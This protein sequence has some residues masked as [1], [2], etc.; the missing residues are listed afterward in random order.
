MVHLYWIGL[1]KNV[2]V[3]DLKF[4]KLVKLLFAL[5][6]AVPFPALITNFGNE[7]H[8]VTA[9]DPAPFIQHKGELKGKVLF[10]NTHGET[11]GAAD[12]VIDGGFSDFAN[13]IADQGYDVKEL[14]KTTPITLSDLQGYDVFVLGES[15][16]PFKTSEQDALLQYV[17]DGGSIFFIGDHYNSDRNLNRWDSGEVY[18]GYRRGAWDDPT[19]G[20][21]TKEANSA[22]MQGVQ[23]SDWLAQNFG[24]RFRTNAL[25]DVTSGET[26]VSPDQSFGITQ[27]VTTVEMHAGSTL[28]ILDPTKAKGL[29]YMPEG[30]PS[31][32]ANA[33]DQGVYNNGGIAEGAFAAISKVGKGKAAFIGDS[34]PV[35]DS[36]PKYLRE[37]TGKAKVT[38][39]GF[40]EE[41][42][43]STFLINTIL[44]LAHHEDYTSFANVPNQ[45]DF[46]LSPVTQLYD[47][48]QPQNSTEPEHEPWSDPPSGYKWWDPSTFAPGSYGSNKPIPSNPQYSFDHQDTLPNHAPF[49]IRLNISDLAPGQTLSNLKVG[50]Y[51]DGGQQ[52][53]KFKNADGSWMT[54]Y[55]YSPEF[56]LTGDTT[57]SAHVDLDV[58]L[59]PRYSGHANLRLKMGSKNVITQN[60]N[61]GDVDAEPLPPYEVNVPDLTSIANARQSADG[62]LVTVEGVITS[63]PGIWGGSGFYLQDN[64]AGVYVFPDNNA[65]YHIGQKV[66]IS[67]IKTLYNGEVELGSIVKSTDEGEGTLPNPKVVSTVDDTNQGQLLKLENVSVQNIVK[68]DNYGTFEFDAVNGDTTTRVRV[69]NRSGMDYYDFILKYS[70]GDVLDITGVGSIF[71]GTYQ[72]KPRSADDFNQAPKIQDIDQLNIF[73][74]DAYQ[75][76]VVVTDDHMVQS[77]DITLDGQSVANP[78]TINPVQL[79]LGDHVIHVTATDNNGKTTE[80]TF[81]LH[82]DMDVDHLD[83]LLDYGVD[84]NFAGQLGNSLEAKVRSVQS[85]PNEKAAANKLNALENEISAQSGKKIN[86]DF[87]NLF[88]DDIDYLLVK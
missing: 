3:Q 87:A 85:A 5:M 10:D 23:S 52:I 60:V 49:Q 58:Q 81:T 4:S 55:N 79:T 17:K 2:E 78:I 45:P 69:D 9:T 38:Y 7:A 83:E 47:W 76:P 34:S 50:I 80:R 67:A 66:K 41:G 27:G 62:S 77:V 74:T 82:V 31:W 61:L 30:V 24:L 51:L 40:S 37:D 29:I 15:N 65:D 6:I 1:L 20:M 25:G 68:T 26:V 33:V 18:N 84:Q 35:E 11:A 46:E 56:S 73:Q 64:T 12:W 54:N 71:K 86:D 72:F 42:Q 63:T 8:A 75:Q 36:T 28:A 14:R 48:E 19:K 59:D 70:E 39:D 16:I 44:W 57:G 22:A 32:G 13:A 53:A 21:T 88:V 43:D